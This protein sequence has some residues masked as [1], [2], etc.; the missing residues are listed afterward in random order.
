MPSRYYTAEPK[1]NNAPSQRAAQKSFEECA[2]N[3][4]SNSGVFSI[5]VEKP[6]DDCK[7][8]LHSG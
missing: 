3:I 7:R 4:I 8:I 6:V 5:K 2:H 1:R